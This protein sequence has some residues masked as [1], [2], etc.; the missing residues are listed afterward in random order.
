[1]K[2]VT[3]T[4]RKIPQLSVNGK[5]SITIQEKLKVFADI[6]QQTVAPNSEADRTPTV[7]TKQAVNDSLKQPLTD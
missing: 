7:T 2:S 3:N 1:M 5:I 6:L 4:N